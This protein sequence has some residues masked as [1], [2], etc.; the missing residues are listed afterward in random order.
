PPAG[1]DA[2]TRHNGNDL[3]FGGDGQDTISGENAN[4]ILNGNQGDDRLRGGPGTDYIRGGQNND[5]LFGDGGNDLL[6]GDLG[7]DSLTGGAGGDTFVLRTDRSELGETIQGADQIT[8]F[9]A[10][11]G[12]RIVLTGEF[13]TSALSFQSIDVDGNG[14]L[15]TVLSYASTRYSSS[16]ESFD[17]VTVYFGTI[18]NQVI[19]A[20]SPSILSLSAG[21][22]L[23]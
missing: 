15:D 17:P 12:D 10:S 11:E 5:Q 6:V 14:A 7:T 22:P 19:G 4:D 8:D 13:S 2:T 9:N 1:A 16:I 23:L 20:T 21:D 3:R 18:M